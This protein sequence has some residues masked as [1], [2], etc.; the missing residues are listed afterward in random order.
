MARVIS[1]RE[2]FEVPRRRFSK[3][4]GTSPTCHPRLRTRWSISI[5]KE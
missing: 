2:I 5:K 1:V 4:I 3:T